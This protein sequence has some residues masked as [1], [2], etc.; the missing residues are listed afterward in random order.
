MSIAGRIFRNKGHILTVYAI[1][2]VAILYLPVLI[3]PVFS[4]NDSQVLSFPLTGFTTKWYAQLG[5]QG[6]LLE[7]LGNSLN[8]A[9]ATAFFS[10]LLGTF[11][12]RAIVKY[13]YPFRRTS[14]VIVMVPLVMPEIIVA[15]SLLILLLGLGFNPSLIA[16][17]MAHVLMT[18]PFCVS[19]MTSAFGQFDDSLEEAA[20]DLGQT[21]WGA[22]TKVT[23]P[24]VAPGLLSSALVS[25]T[26]SF[27]EFML[28]F[29]LSGNSPTLPVYIWSQVRFPAKLPIVLAL[30]SLMI[31]ASL[32]LLVTAEYFRRRNLRMAMKPEGNS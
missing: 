16:V 8:V 25:F 15:I 32:I 1:I 19:I 10:T 18:I 4:F 17:T 29:F 12:A 14:Q 28:S 30:G 2:Y 21:S 13:R 24:V 11:V 9:L 22:L 23:L 27:D 7:S 5:D 31:L 20:I 6:A 26:V 3:L